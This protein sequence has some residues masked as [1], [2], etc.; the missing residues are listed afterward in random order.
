MVTRFKRSDLWPNT[1][2]SAT[3]LMTQ[4]TGEFPLRVCSA[5]SIGICMADTSSQELQWSKRSFIITNL[6]SFFLLSKLM[7]FYSIKIT[8]MQLAHF[9]EIQSVYFNEIFI[10]LSLSYVFQYINHFPRN[11]HSFHNVLLLSPN[12][13]HILLEIYIPH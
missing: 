9:T 8:E 11:F 5:Q 12:M 1:L 4:D 3:S 6:F 13:V 10:L 7:G 2:H